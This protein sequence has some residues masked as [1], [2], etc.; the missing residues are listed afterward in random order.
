MVVLAFGTKFGVHFELWEFWVWSSCQILLESGILFGV[1]V[2]HLF[3]SGWSGCS[4]SLDT[5]LQSFSLR[6]W[7]HPCQTDS[8][9]QMLIVAWT[10][11]CFEALHAELPSRPQSNSPFPNSILFP[12]SSMSSSSISSSVFSSVKLC[13]DQLSK[14]CAPSL[15]FFCQI[16]FIERELPWSVVDCLWRPLMMSE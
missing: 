10:G 5:Q 12:F 14:L 16:F 6:V 8:A 3:W 13:W 9:S 15:E 11:S 1:W 7:E 4:G 2:V